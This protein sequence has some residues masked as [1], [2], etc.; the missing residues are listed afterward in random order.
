MTTSSIKPEKTTVATPNNE[1][2][3]PDNVLFDKP[4]EIIKH[5]QPV[6]PD[7][8]RKGGLE[9]DVWVKVWVDNKGN[10]KKVLVTENSDPI[11]HQPAIE[12]AR[13]FVFNPAMKER[14][15]VDVWVTFPFH[16]R[17]K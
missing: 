17:L 4:P 1:L 16:F 15:P 9:G 7:T 2:P 11:F 5:V 3:P 8:A 13:Q 14:K 6:Y 10:V 12:A